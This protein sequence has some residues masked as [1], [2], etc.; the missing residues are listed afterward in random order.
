MLRLKKI[1]K[2]D[3][4]GLSTTAGILHDCG[5]D[6]AE[7]YQLYH[8]KNAYI[9]SFLIVILCA[10]K[11]QIYLVY[12]VNS[13]VAAFMTRKQGQVLHFEKLAT[14]PSRS[15][16]GIGSFCMTKIEEIARKQD[17]TKITMEVYESSR[18]AISFYE[19]K[20]YAVTGATETLKYK[21]IIMEK[22]I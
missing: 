20:G 19:H 10:L 4:F 5:R 18:H 3:I 13:A 22:S 17:C 7:R 21:E 6:M 15:G 14:V 2:Y 8:W 16:K 9:K 1:R 11:N 12:D